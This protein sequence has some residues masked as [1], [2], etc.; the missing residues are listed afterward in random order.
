LAEDRLFQ[1]TLRAYSTQGR[2]SEFLG[3]RPLEYDKFMRE[4]NLKG[5]ADK[6]AAR[7][8]AENPAEYDKLNLLALGIN[9]RVSKMPI[10]PI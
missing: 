2:L 7:L 4:V 6:R 9:D 5:W 1:L 3:E 8:Q 10:L